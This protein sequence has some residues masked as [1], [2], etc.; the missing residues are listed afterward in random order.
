MW[1][2]VVGGKMARDI[3]LPDSTPKFWTCA[4]CRVVEPVA[5]ITL[6][7][8]MPLCPDCSGAKQDSAITAGGVE[9]IIDRI[10]KQG[11]NKLSLDRKARHPRAKRRSKVKP[12]KN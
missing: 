2:A 3:D 8:K 1:D 9:E 5:N 11:R 12:L 4:N 6:I 7:G 10:L